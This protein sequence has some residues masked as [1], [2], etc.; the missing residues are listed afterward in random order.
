M[1][2]LF[3]VFLFLSLILFVV[4]SHNF[5]EENK[6]KVRLQN[7]VLKIIKD[8]C[9]K[10]AIFVSIIHIHE[11]SDDFKFQLFEKIFKLDDVVSISIQTT[12]AI[13]TSH[14]RFCNIFIIE[15]FQD[16]MKI[17]E[18][19]TPKFFKFSGFYTLLAT[20]GMIIETEK[21]FQLL[22]SKQ[23]YNA[24]IL[25]EAEGAVKALGFNSF[26][27]KS[28]DNVKPLE[29]TNLMNFFPDKLQDLKRCPIKVHSPFLP[30][31]VFIENNK[32]TGR[33]IDL[34]KIIAKALNF[35]LKL[36]VLTQQGAWGAVLEN[37]TSTHATKS[38]LESEIDIIISEFYLKLLRLKYLEA[39][40]VYIETEIV[41]AIPPGRNLL[42][43]EK[44][45]Q[46]FAI[47]VWV[48]L[49]VSLLTLFILI[50]II[51]WS[52]KIRLTSET[53][54]IFFR[55]FSIMFGVSQPSLPKRSYARILM[56]SLIIFCILI[57][58]SYQGSLYRFIQTNGKVKEAQ[59][60][61]EMIDADYKFYVNDLKLDMLRNDAKIMER[62]E[63]LKKN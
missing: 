10:K 32:P 12:A 51:I 31:F 57:Q 20:N 18:T 30:P 3:K 21:I 15:K 47:T 61:D 33:D 59:S 60:I 44:L 8:T 43:I 54:K 41:F 34:I 28:C 19:L 45:F 24:V 63:N 39:S 56:M 6:I 4:A 49:S 48:I 26:D 46:P 27:S 16:F 14:L 37:G 29:I 52:L 25:Y 38:L 50:F 1:A 36:K 40:N 7:V 9:V 62:W 23:I 17:Y 11:L 22:W 53:I 58:A 2:K 35:N 42:S 13:G 5:T 55:I